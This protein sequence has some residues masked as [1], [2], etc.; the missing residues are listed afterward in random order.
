MKT[1][2]TTL[3][4]ALIAA[5]ARAESLEWAE[6]PPLPD[7]HG[8]AGPFAGTS[9][10]ALIVAGG[11]NF[12][13]GYPWDGGAKI[14]HDRAFVLEK[15]DGAWQIAAP[16]P[17]PVGYGV[18]ASLASRASLVCIGGND[19][20]ATFADCFELTWV[21]G[22]LK[23]SPLPPLPVASTMGCGAAIGDVVYHAGGS[24]DGETHR[25]FY[26]LDLGAERP[27]WEELPWPEGAPG[28]ILAVAGVSGGQF[29][30]FG[31]ADLGSDR[32]DKRSYLNDAWR[33]D[34]EAGTWQR[35]ADMPAQVAAGPSPAIAAGASHLLLLGGAG[36]D[37]VEAQ[38]ALRPETDGN[39]VDHPGFPKRQLA[40]HTV[41][42]TWVETGGS[43]PADRLTPVTT[44]TVAWQ[45][46]IVVPTG[47]VKPGIRSP[48][49]LLAETTSDKP[50]FG[51]VNWL[52][53][54]LY[55]GAMVAIGAWFS[56]RNKSTD[57]FFRGGQ[58]VPWA[59]AGLSIFATMLSAL[60]FMG[61][62]ARAYMTDVSW[63]LGQLPILIVVPVVVLF[64]LPRFRKL[65][66][67]SAYEFLEHRFDLFARLFAS[68]S[69]IL[70]HIGRMAI[71]V[72]LPA[73]ALAQVSSI[74]V[75]TCIVLIGILCVVYTVM[76][77]IEAVG[78]TDAVQA[79]VLMGGALL[80]MV[81][82]FAGV[83][84]G[85]G[86][87][88]ETA[89]ADGKLFQN[90]EA[91]FDIRDGTASFLVLFV[92][93]LFNSLVPY[94]SSQDLVQRYVTTP[95]EAEARRSLWTTMWMSVFGSIIFFAL[96]VALYAFYK[97]Q[98]ALLD[99][100]MEKADAI[101]PFFILGQLPAGVAGLL[102]AAIFAAAQSTVSSS[103]NSVATA[104]VT[105]FHTRLFRPRGGDRARLKVA[106]VAV[107][108]VGSLGITVAIVMAKSEMESAFKTFNSLIG[109][110]AGALGGLF[111]LGVFNRRATALGAAVGAVSG[112][113]TV[114]TLYLAKAPVTGLLY[115]LIGFAVCFLVGSVVSLATPRRTA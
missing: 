51:I 56:R 36:R 40:Y 101:L 84:G 80:C 19:A 82:V 7:E 78:W 9:G 109:L 32:W 105:D 25:A 72:Y 97:A 112:F 87:V 1:I 35:L 21:G 50:A 99:P 39:G 4:I 46:G 16:L 58:R 59:V 65:D 85:A 47:E 113:A 93:F 86:A 60:T 31:G 26:R 33:F 76:G 81:L 13:D 94:T 28:R 14:Y 91:S 57:D 38:R 96:G 98:P 64:Y 53:V 75:V 110:A 102:I 48:Q 29:Y 73:L 92:A 12:P 74:D 77:G 71:V 103:L 107:V 52:V 55:L 17:K 104:Y 95:T 70:F 37:F 106:R 34:P 18:S 54:V 2:A 42:D 43:F 88:W 22:A 41:T 66:I 67:T 5:D 3:L 30:L 10:G 108:A 89:V 62:P 27:A 15:P 68:T 23:A 79:V 44:P 6:L 49:V 90:L 11:A 115:A 83:E 111:A 45:G 69:F 63:Y 61:I 114:V 24:L 8:F 100:A 20:D